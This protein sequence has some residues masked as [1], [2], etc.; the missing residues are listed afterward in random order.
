MPKTMLDYF[1]EQ[2]AA[3]RGILAGG[4]HRAKPFAEAWQGRQPDRLYLVASGS[5]HNA[6]A[7]AAP[8]MQRM[9]GV[10]VFACAPS[11]LPPIGGER[12]FFIFISQGGASTNTIAAIEA[13][14]GYPALAVTGEEQCR[15]NELC[16]QSVLIGCGPEEVG[17][18]TKGYTGTI[19]TLYLMAMEAG[20][21]CGSVDGGAYGSCLAALSKMVD[22]MGEN[23]CRSEDWFARNVDGLKTFASCAHVGKNLASLS[24]L[25]TSLKMLETVLVP[26]APYEFEEYLH[27]PVFAL[28]EH[29]AGIYLLPPKTD[30]DYT[31]MQAMAA[32]H[33]SIA[34]Q[35][36]TIGAEAADGRDCAL[37]MTGEEYTMPFEW[38]LPAQLLSARV[39]EL[40]GTVGRGSQIFKA[41]DKALNI[42]YKEG[43]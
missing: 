42:K 32:F 3:L 7:V 24:A 35:V 30:R 20:L 37:V 9:L 13:L 26:S 40:L 21:A 15:I 6:S 23:L 18:K 39:P 12:P 25:E 22:N 17:P 11:Y 16:G 4:P 14:K 1:H 19:L 29:A 5:S 33:R 36:Y 28:K 38:V 10:E 43:D 8:F 27:G 41:L 2:P 31:R 34:Q